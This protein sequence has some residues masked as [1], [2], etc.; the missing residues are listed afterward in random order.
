M[1]WFLALRFGE[2]AIANCSVLCFIAEENY[3]ILANEKNKK[4]ANA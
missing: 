4:L 1:K 3:I 2:E